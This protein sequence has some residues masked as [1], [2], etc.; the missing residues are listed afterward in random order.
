MAYGGAIIERDIVNPL[1]IL[2][3]EGRVVLSPA[4]FTR[5]HERAKEHL[6]QLTAHNGDIVMTGN[7]V[8]LAHAGRRWSSLERS[9][10]AFLSTARRTASNC[11]SRKSDIMALASRIEADGKRREHWFSHDQ[12]AIFDNR[13]ARE[14]LDEGLGDLLV[15][16]LLGIIHGE[17]SVAHADGN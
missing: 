9:D 15:N 3:K 5:H 13:T 11:D 1:A 16:F 17:C 7:V 4:V 2:R 6:G 14:M 8:L 12:I 10:I